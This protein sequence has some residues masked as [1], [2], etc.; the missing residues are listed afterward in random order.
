MALTSGTRLGPYEIRSPLGAGGMGEVYRAADT[1]LGRD[2]ALKVLPAAMARDPEFLARF[3][4]EARTVAALNHPH[5]VTIYSV[6]EAEGVHFLTMELVE[7]QP[8]GRLIPSGG[9]P[10]ARLVE[11]GAE[12]ADALSAAHAKGIVHR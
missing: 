12:L 2:V 5:I 11:I 10:V 4:R 1:K 9:M 7:G 8:L 6:E 3:K